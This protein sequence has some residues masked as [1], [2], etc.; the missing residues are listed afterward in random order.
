MPLRLIAVVAV[1]LLVP[2][3]SS[4]AADDFEQLKARNWHQ[5]RGP[6][7]TGVAPQASPPVEWSES[8]NLKWKAEIPGAGKSSPIIW[9][10]KVFITTAVDTGK[11]VPGAPKPEDQPERMFG[12]KFPNTLYRFVVFALDRE[13]GKVVWEQTAVEELPHE[14]HHGD[15]SHASASPTTD[16][17]RLYVSFGSRGMYCYD[18]SGRKL[19][20]RKLPKVETRL[21]FGEGSS[22]VVHED[23]VV[24][25]RDNETASS[26]LAFDAATGEVKWEQKRTEPSAWATP[27]VVDHGGRTQVITNASNKV[28]SYDLHTGDVIWE[29]GGQV[30]NVT[31]SPVPVGDDVICMSGYRGSM[32]MRIPLNAKGDIT[33]SAYVEWKYD[34]DTPYVPS[35]LLYGDLLYFN[36]LN[37]NILT[38]LNVN[39]GTTVLGPTRVDQVQNIYASPVGAAGH[40]YLTGRNGTTAVLKQGEKL[41]IVATNRLEDLIDASAAIAGRQLMLRGR[42]TLYCFENK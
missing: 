37:N 20:E 17:K 29:C 41:D 34:K 4:S 6:L 39:T 38:V 23:T 7:A 15:N 31:P 36:K 13:T 25:V 21:S 22:P 12:I 19:W 11:V 24:L 1:L 32:A 2:A 14:G 18:L 28:R 16:G 42:K 26:I 3:S 9:E 40:V 8:K 33:D 10:D 5:W 30:A 35:P 27:L